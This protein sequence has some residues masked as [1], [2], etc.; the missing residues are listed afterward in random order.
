MS[1]GGMMCAKTCVFMPDHELK[2]WPGAF[3]DIVDGV[4]TFEVREDD[5]GFRLEDSIL[6]REYHPTKKEYTGRSID[7]V[8]TY[9]MPGG[10]FGIA[11]GHCVMGIK[12]AQVKG[13]C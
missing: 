10:Q 1:R 4:K 8:V 3:Q 6:L 9:I 12:P 5:R 11:E 7:V 13:K 2:T